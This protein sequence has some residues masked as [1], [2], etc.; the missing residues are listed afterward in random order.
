MVVIAANLRAPLTSVGPLVGTIRESL[1]LSAAWAGAITTLPL[2]AFALLSPFASRLARRFGMETVLFAAIGLLAAG[3][4]VRSLAGTAALFLGTALLGLAIAVCNVLMPALVKREFPENVG[5]LTGVY[6]VSMNLCGAIASGVSVPL[7]AG[8][9]LGWKG[10]LGCWAALALIA[11][12]LWLPQ[13]RGRSRPSA[14]PSAGVKPTKLWRSPLAWQVTL[15]MG[16]QSLI[17]YVTV[18]WLPAILGGR[19]MSAGTAGWMLSLLQFAL[20]PF[21]FVVP[22]LAGR[23]KSQRPLVALTTALYVVGIGGLLVG[24]N[25]W[26]PLWTIVLGIGG[27]FAFS[28]AM[29]FFTLRTRTAHEAAELSGMAQS[30]GYLLAAVGPALFG[31]LHDAAGGWT[32]PLLLLLAASLL[33][34]ACGMG[35]AKRRYVDEER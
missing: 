12:A 4:A 16:L 5:M 1:T 19:G 28:L 2:L 18:A 33:I 29:M 27:G 7:A 31:M 22:V 10:A 20:L 34:F 26:I 9:G 25:G 17:F 32:A 13:L 11:V 15:F 24:G 35:A 30:V 14:S 23:M 3:I 6:S 21:T 8:A